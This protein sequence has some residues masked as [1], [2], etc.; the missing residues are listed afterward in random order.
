MS[1]AGRRWGMTIPLEDRGLTGLPAIAAELSGLGYTD[2]WT[3][4]V[5]YADGLTPLAAV[6]T[7]APDAVLGTAIL[8]VFTRGP[9]VLAVS[10]ASMATL[11]PGR[12][13]LGIG[14]SSPAVVQSWNAAEFRA[15]YART[16]DVLTFLREALAGGRV[17]RDY[18]TFSVNGFRLRQVPEVPPPILVAGLRPRM[19]RLAATE[20]DGAIT[21]W[22]SAGDVPAVREAMGND[23][24]LV[25]RIMVCPSTDSELVRA[26]ARR[27]IA[28][29]LTVP[30]YSAFQQWLGRGPALAEMARH[31]AASDRAAALAAIS[32]EVVDEL[33]VHGSPEECVA[34]VERYVAAGVNVPVLHVLPWGLDA[35]D[36]ARSL[37]PQPPVN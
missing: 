22:L 34:H 23:K 1:P 10:A 2:L 33:I 11:A 3:S 29:Y 17:Q 37:A 6:A 32:D 31:W 30:A 28:A 19:L 21:N 20:G 7:S 16:R 4:E 14:A 9:A 5:D 8:P 26:Q 18:E 35:L 24:E 12:F 27:L 15:P 25:A 13:C 36:A